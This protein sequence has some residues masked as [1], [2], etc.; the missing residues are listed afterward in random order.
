MDSLGPSSPPPGNLTRHSV[1]TPVLGCF[2]RASM[3]SIS[4]SPVVGLLLQITV[5]TLWVSM[6]P[7]SFR[8]QPYYTY[9]L[10]VKFFKKLLRWIVVEPYLRIA[11]RCIEVP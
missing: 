5:Q 7:T 3:T 4:I 9:L 6:T 11:Q 10:F 1:Q 2:E 8:L